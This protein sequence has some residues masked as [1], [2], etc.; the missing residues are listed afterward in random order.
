[1][2]SDEVTRLARQIFGRPQTLAVI[3]NLKGAK[4][5]VPELA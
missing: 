3:G 2:T 5:R 1:V 4:L